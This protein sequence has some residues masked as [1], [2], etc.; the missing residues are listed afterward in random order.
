MGSIG[1]R[2][3]AI[4][5][6]YKKRGI[7]MRRVWIDI[8]NQKGYCIIK[9]PDKICDKDSVIQTKERNIQ[10]LKKEIGNCNLSEISF[11]EDEDIDFNEYKIFYDENRVDITIIK[12][13]NEYVS[14]ILK[15]DRN[16][17][18][19]V[20]YRGHSNYKY[21]LQPSIYR[22]DN[23]NIL[24][25]EDKL[26]RDI[27]S[28][29][30]HFFNDCE[31]TLDKLVKMQHHGIPTRLLDLTDNPLI[32]LFFACKSSENEKNKHAEVNIFNI[33]E[34]K[35]KYYDSDTVSVL[36]NI[37]K[38]SK[39]FNISSYNP[40]VG[41]EWLRI[42]GYHAPDRESKVEEFYSDKI[43]E[44]NKIKQISEL[45]HFIR[46]E[47]AYFLPKVDMR[48]LDNFSLVVKPKWSIDRI[49]NQS[50]AFVIFGIKKEKRKCGDFNVNK[51]DYK[52]KVLLIPSAY[53]ESIL[54]ELKLFN[55]NESTVFCDI[56]STARFFKEKY[57]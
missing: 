41:S 29:K 51:N 45:V 38:C 54:E 34:E 30:P 12:N 6:L 52:Q 31:T 43:N 46:D 50:G 7:D 17:D 47:K 19:Q 55:I 25:K 44:F 1:F 49:I 15:I 39:E 57:K 2:G 26:F 48:N 24:D 11:K 5:F 28:S 40:F 32:A 4:K 42:I 3:S 35:I 33:P 18:S 27:I 9:L 23:K 22:E 36:T 14:N 37:A 8:F 13:L 21:L 20:Y 56:D 53:K 16:Q 10:N